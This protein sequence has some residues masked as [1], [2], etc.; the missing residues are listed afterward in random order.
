MGYNPGAKIYRLKFTD[1][2]GLI[3]RV[4]S[5]PIGD[6]LAVVKM[7][8]IARSVSDDEALEELTTLLDI[9]A[10]YLVSWNIELPVDPTDENSPVEPVPANRDGLN[11]LD[12]ELTIEIVFSWI[13]AVAGVAT[14]LGKTSIDGETL[15][16][17]SIPMEA[18][19]EN[20]PS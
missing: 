4:L 15:Q 11:R 7:A 17:E 1:R 14:P 3:V 19:S 12:F 16:E 20:H 10:K 2:D 9:L 5:L 18:L 6:F 8:D 13:D